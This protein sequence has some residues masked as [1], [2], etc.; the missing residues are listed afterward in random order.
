MVIF[1]FYIPLVKIIS[2]FENMNDTILYSKL[3]ILPEELKS[4]VSQFI[5]SLLAK[6]KKSTK[7]KKPVFGS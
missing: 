6:A 1:K 2:K 4:E 5:D 7:K 3:S